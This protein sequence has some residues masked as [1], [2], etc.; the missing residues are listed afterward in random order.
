MAV[1]LTVDVPKRLYEALRRRAR[2][3]NTSIDALILQAIA[4]KHPPDRKPR[5]VRG[6]MIKGPGPFGPAFPVDEN[7]HDFIIP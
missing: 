4:E 3:L 2:L 1:R 6:P 7:P 5:M